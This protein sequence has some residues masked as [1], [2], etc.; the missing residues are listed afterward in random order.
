[1]KT[2]IIKYIVICY[3]N[4]QMTKVIERQK[5]KLD[6]LIVEKIIEEGL[7]NNPN[8]LINNLTSK[9]LSDK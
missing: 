8:N 6:G 1:M 4:K 7:Q 9:T 2:Q 3:I 5:K